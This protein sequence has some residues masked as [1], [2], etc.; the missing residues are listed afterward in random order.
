MTGMKPAEFWRLTPWEFQ[1]WLDGWQWAREDRA[2]IN[3]HFTASLMN[4]WV[5]KKVK[6]RDL[7]RSPRQKA[8]DEAYIQARK[9]RFEEAVRRMGPEVIPLSD[10]TKQHINMCQ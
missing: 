1:E 7:F 4:C 3:A 8:R 10:R 6:G 5:K 2:G 9:R